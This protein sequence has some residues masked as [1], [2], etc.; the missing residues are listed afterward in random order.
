MMKRDVKMIKL[1]RMSAKT[2][3]KMRTKMRMKAEPKVREQDALTLDDAE[4]GG[5]FK[6]AFLL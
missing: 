4:E 1:K 2:K 3:E 6:S 5:C